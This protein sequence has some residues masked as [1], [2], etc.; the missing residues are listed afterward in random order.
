MAGTPPIV[1]LSTDKETY[2]TGDRLLLTI[3]HT[4]VD[5]ATLTVTSEVTDSAGN[6]GSGSVVVS[7]DGGKVTKVTGAFN[8]ARSA[9]P[10]WKLESASANVSVYSTTV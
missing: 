2:A 1:T 5:R 6:V 3:N 7:I 9:A 8:P 4:D 10:V